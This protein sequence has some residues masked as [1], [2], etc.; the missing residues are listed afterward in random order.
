MTFTSETRSGTYA[1]CETAWSTSY[2]G[3]V[4]LYT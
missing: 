1:E 2:T 4:Y 3:S